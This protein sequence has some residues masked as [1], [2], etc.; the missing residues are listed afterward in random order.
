MLHRVGALWLGQVFTKLLAFVAFAYLARKLGTEQYGAVEYA[1]GLATFGALAVEGG[2]GS[3]GVRRLAQHEQSVERLAALV[4]AAQSCLALVV[5]P[6][7][8]L[9]A[10]LFA[11]DVRAVSLVGLVALSVLILPWKQ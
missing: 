9:L 8:V 11:N 10:A 6:G 4:P 5:A 2:L 1:M 7:I 3:V